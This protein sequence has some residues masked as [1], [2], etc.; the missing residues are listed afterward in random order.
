MQQK[1]F[2]ATKP[3]EEKQLA[4]EAS[5]DHLKGLEELVKKFKVKKG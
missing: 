3:D 4:V 2:L 1:S 5:E